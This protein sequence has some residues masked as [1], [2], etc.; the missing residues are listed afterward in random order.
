VFPKETYRDVPPFSI[1]RAW[2]DHWFIKA[3]RLNG[4]PIVDVTRVAQAIHQ[5]HDYSHV[6]GGLEWVLGG[7]EAEKNQR[8]YGEKDLLRYTLL[9]A[10]HELTPTGRIRRI[11]LRKSVFKTRHFLWYSF[12]D[13]TFALRNRLGLRR[14]TSV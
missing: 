9:D 8:L 6:K 4:M 7:Q 13:H 14:R 1:G 5:N 3:A 12:L 11:F 10:T 2:F